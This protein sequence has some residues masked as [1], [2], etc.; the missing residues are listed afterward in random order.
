MI[1]NYSIFYSYQKAR[2]ILTIKFNDLKINKDVKRGNVF[3]FY[4]DDELVS[5]IIDG[6]D[7]IIKIHAEGL[8]PLPN[9]MMIDVINTFLKKENLEQ[10]SYKKHSGY[11][12]GEVKNV[13]GEVEVNTINNT[14]KFSNY[15]NLLDGDKVI[16]ASPNIFL[17]NGEYNKEPHL[18]SYKDLDISDNDA[19]IV[20]NSLIVNEDFITLEAK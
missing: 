18:C 3:I 16:V 19:L 17:F 4:H 6:I 14:Y 10:L 12:V 9:D 1:E 2:N 8:I 15:F 7:K 20:D 13:N 5:Y 11:Y